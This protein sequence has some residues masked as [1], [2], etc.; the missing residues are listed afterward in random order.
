V[1]L[2]YHWYTATGQ[3][4]VWDGA[5][6]KLPA[7]L[8]AGATV[9]VQ[10]QVTAPAQGGNYSLR[11][12]LV[13]EGVAWFS[14]KGVPT[15]NV[16]LVVAGPFIKSYGATYAP[17]S[18]S[19][20]M[21]RTTVTVPVTVTNTS[22]FLWS[23][24][25]ATP[26]NLSYH[27]IDSAGRAAVWDG[28]RTKLGADLQPGAAA[29]LQ[30]QLTYPS[31]A[32]TYTLRWDMVEE[33]VTWFSGKDVGTASQSVQ[34]DAFVT[35]FYGGSLDVSGTP[36]QLAAV[37]TGYYAVKVQNL[38]NFTWGSDVNISYH[39]L[40]GAGNAVLWDG[41]RTSLQGM[42][43]NELRAV[44][45]RVT[46]PAQPGSY[47]LRYDIV[48]E[49]VTWFSD[50]GMQTPTKP[51]QVAVAGY[52]A[53]YAPGAPA[54]SGAAGATITV[55]VTITNVGTAVWQPGTINAS[56]HLFTSQGAV[57]VWD[58]AR[59]KLAAPLDK[60]QGASVLLQV[61][62]PATAGTYELR[63]DLVQEG[64]TWFSGQGIAPATVTLSVQ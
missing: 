10:A 25:G 34:V 38:S 54:A 44:N 39:W 47:V 36:A 63:V 4:A 16:P 29:N 57:F 5:R 35:P 56:Y 55:P 17:A 60:T 42:R 52:A 30:A 46:P 18:V 12:D 61:V 28:A 37:A 13:Q 27:W 58:G 33:G 6:T 45:I 23:P 22:N 14:N 3:A 24:S 11:F 41:A 48:R 7:D 32:G 53:T 31:A 49:G 62:L 64:I 59:T 8:P 2:G 1:N 50:A 20:A 9:T 19:A 40:D 43:P 21:A 51:V 15:G 26:E